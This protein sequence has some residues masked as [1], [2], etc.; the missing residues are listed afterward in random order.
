MWFR[1]LQEQVR[2]NRL[3]LLT[4]FPFI[5]LQGPCGC[6]SL[7]SMSP[8]YATNTDEVLVNPRNQTWSI[9]SWWDTMWLLK[10]FLPNVDEDHLAVIKILLSNYVQIT[11]I[12]LCFLMPLLEF[13]YFYLHCLWTYFTHLFDCG[14]SAC[15]FST[16]LILSKNRK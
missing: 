1:N 9:F 7:F 13:K 14:I 4:F 6:L 5:I 3:L 12:F 15:I 16:K 2:K 10:P 8:I 11:A